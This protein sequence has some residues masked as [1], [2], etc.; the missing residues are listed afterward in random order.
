MLNRLRR[1]RSHREVEREEQRRVQEGGRDRE[2]QR[3][4]GGRVKITRLISYKQRKE[5]FR[6]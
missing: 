2:R 1:R 6:E 5:Y 3:E 4:M